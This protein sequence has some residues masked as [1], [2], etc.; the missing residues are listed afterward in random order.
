VYLD[1]GDH[2]CIVCHALNGEL[3]P[4][5]GGKKLSPQLRA[6]Q[7]EKNRVTLGV[8]RWVIV[9]E[10]GDAGEATLTT[11]VHRGATVAP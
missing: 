6:E 7:A 10:F 4:S 5:C 8:D 2:L 11:L 1:A 9:T 3:A